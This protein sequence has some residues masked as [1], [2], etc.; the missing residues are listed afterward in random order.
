MNGKLANILRH[1]DS[2]ILKQEENTQYLIELLRKGFIINPKTDEKNS[3]WHDLAARLP[4]IMDEKRSNIVILSKD[5]LTI[6][7]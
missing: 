2:E 3:Q 7:K 1:I 6:L 5:K 4:S